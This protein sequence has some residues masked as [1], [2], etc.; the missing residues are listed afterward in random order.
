[1]RATHDVTFAHCA[2]A[3]IAY[4]DV[5]SGLPT[6]FVHG[7]PHNR[8]LWAA[9]TAALAGSARCLAVDLRGFGR[10]SVAGPYTVDRYADDVACVLDAAG[11]AE[12]AVVGLSMGGYVALALWRRHR[13]R[14]R[15][16]ALVSTRATADD[17]AAREKRRALIERARH[18]GSEA[19]ADDQVTGAVSRA[20]LER[21][22]ELVRQIVAMQS[23][24]PAEGIVGAL[25]AMM[26][27]PDST[28]DL[29]GITV[30][31]IVI[32]GRDDS[33]I[34]PSTARALHA[35]IPSSR[36]ELLDRA[37]HLCNLERAAAFNHVLGEFLASVTVA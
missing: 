15:A 7:F 1:V 21:R 36:L 6:V 19:V 30:P 13:T 25:E 35:S 37:G 29:A 31:T 32:A 5:G 3:S 22:P 24:A 11:V 2:G 14:V 34:R 28:G 10:S 17:D 18:E 9:Q 12:A 33:L 16:L 26:A 8:T 23:S 27:R 4:A 20:T